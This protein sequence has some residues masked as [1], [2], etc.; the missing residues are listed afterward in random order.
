MTELIESPDTNL[1]K[2]LKEAGIEIPPT[3]LIGSKFDFSS[4]YG[5]HQQS[6]VGTV[7]GITWSDEGGLKFFVS[8]PE[9]WGVPMNCLVYTE[10]RWAALMEV[11][12][13][14]LMNELERVPDD[15]PEEVTEG[16]IQKYFN[17]RLLP[18][19]LILL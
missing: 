10:N 19:E 12:D 4:S 8:I 2:A 18:G 11:D 9:I 1:L 16:I 17:R 14:D 6:L 7:T 5:S 3:L 13:A 15:A